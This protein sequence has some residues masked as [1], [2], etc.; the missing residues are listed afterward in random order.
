MP[1]YRTEKLQQPIEKN[2][3]CLADAGFTRCLDL[4]PLILSLACPVCADDELF[5]YASSGSGKAEY[6][7]F[8]KGHSLETD[9]TMEDLVRSGL[10]GRK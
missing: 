7:S 2:H 6:V 9:A 8:H 10:V 1:E 3:V 5:F 4:Y